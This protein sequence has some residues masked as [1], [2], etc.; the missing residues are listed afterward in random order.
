MQNPTPP[1]PLPIPTADNA[2]ITADSDEWTA[3]GACLTNGGGALIP[4]TGPVGDT[5]AGI[6]RW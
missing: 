3:D 6:R 5:H 4:D 1:V 2:E